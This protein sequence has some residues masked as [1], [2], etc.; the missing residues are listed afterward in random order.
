MPEIRAGEKMKI[1][2][3]FAALAGKILISGMLIA[4]LLWRTDLQPI[5]ARL[6]KMDLA[7]CGA[8]LLVF[9]V[10]LSFLGLRWEKISA[11]IGAPLGLRPAIRMTAI[12]WFFNQLL[13]SSFGGDAMRAWVAHR[14]GTPL[15]KAA[16]GVVLDRVVGLTALILLIGLTVPLLYHAVP[17]GLPIWPLVAVFT[18]AATGA[19]LVAAFGRQIESTLMQWRATRFLASFGRDLREVGGDLPR[20]AALLGLSVGLHGLTIAQMYVIG[21]AVMPGVTPLQYLAL[22]PPVLLLAALPVSFA[23]WGVR[24]GTMV[25]VFGAIGVAPAD[26]LSLSLVYGLLLMAAG[27]PGAVFWLAERRRADPVQR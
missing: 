14:S 6:E 22:V 19:L 24:E 10:Q 4:L 16:H 21:G 8:V 20:A 3:K 5:A 9:L 18:C 1:D 15:A 23:G 17:S 25:V 2:G 13:P 12:G 11:A 27:L 26:A 7:R